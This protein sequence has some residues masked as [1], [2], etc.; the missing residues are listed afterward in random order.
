[1]QIKVS[2]RDNLIEKIS[3]NDDFLEEWDEEYSPA[4]ISYRMLI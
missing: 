3:D 4:R 1:M 2:F